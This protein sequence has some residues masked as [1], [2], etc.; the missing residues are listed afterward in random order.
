MG[1]AVPVASDG[2]SMLTVL[3]ILGTIV[4]LFTVPIATILVRTLP[5][6]SRV[7][8]VAGHATAHMLYQGV[9][10]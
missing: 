9:S 4:A 1:W 8:L 6:T 7:L 2:N 3:M 5:G 10:G